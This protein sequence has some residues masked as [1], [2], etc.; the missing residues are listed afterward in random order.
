MTDTKYFPLDEL[1]D[2][3]ENH[4]HEDA[5]E[6]SAEKDLAFIGTISNQTDHSFSLPSSL[7][8]SPPLSSP[9][10]SSSSPLLSSPPLF[11]LS[12]TQ[13]RRLTWIELIGYTYKRFDYLT[14]KKAI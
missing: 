8:S 2:V 10:L 7:L 12:T 6:V 9:L 14:R 3:P 1:E 5:P 11:A 4:N 13:E